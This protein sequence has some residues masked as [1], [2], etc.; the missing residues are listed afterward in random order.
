MTNLRHCR[1]WS[2]VLAVLA[3]SQAVPPVAR[4]QAGDEDNKPALKS[5]GPERFPFYLSDRPWRGKFGVLAWLS[6][7]AKLPIVADYQPD[8]HLGHI[9]SED[10]NG[11]SILY[12]LPE[13]IDLLNDELT[14]TH[15][16]LLMRTP[17][18][19]KLLATN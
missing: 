10:K 14:R 2:L 11:K 18:S 8:G 15:F 4:A 19:I 1:R 6:K 9:Q 3:C 7:Q 12:T 5:R 17:T 13:I 16:F